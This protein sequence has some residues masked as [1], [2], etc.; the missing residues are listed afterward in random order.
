MIN[1]NYFRDIS[2]RIIPYIA[3]FYYVEI[4]Y[5]MFVL[6]F[7]LGKVPA[8]IAGITLAV[9]LSFQIVALFS[10]RD[11]SRKI[12]LFLMDIHFAYSAAFIFSRIIADFPLS[13]GDIA[14]TIFRGAAVLVE[15][16]MIIIL[17][18][19]FIISRYR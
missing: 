16:P 10:R 3:T 17:T 12:Q 9:L 6:N 11:L 4:I 18:D 14:V 8:V 7:L 19:E 15:L 2:G 13:G 1:L 5:L